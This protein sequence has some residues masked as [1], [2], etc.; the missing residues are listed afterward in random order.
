MLQSR[1]CRAQPRASGSL[2]KLLLEA[3]FELKMQAGL[4]RDFC[5]GPGRARFLVPCPLSLYP[6]V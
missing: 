1:H 5:C 2:D 6:H 3:V 4:V